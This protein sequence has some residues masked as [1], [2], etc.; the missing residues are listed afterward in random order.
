[1]KAFRCKR[2]RFLVLPV[3]CVFFADIADMGLAAGIELKLESPH[4]KIVVTLHDGDHLKY[5]ILF[6]GKLVVTDSTLGIIVDGR[7]LGE[8]V[9]FGAPET[10]TINEKYPVMGVH[11]TATNHCDFS[12]IPISSRNTKWQLAVRVFDDGVAYRYQ[13]PGTGARHIDGE[14]SEWNM[15]VGSRLFWQDAANTSYESK[16]QMLLIGQSSPGLEL[17]A[18]A[19]LQ[20][21]DNAG[22][23]TMTEANLINYS[24][25]SLR[26]DG[27]YVA[28]LVPVDK[29]SK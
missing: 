22:Y 11:N 7:D 29:V 28:W 8:D 21:P 6:Q 5:N 13:I 2:F 1:V 4:R 24:D 14:S 23:G 15:P 12:M 16:F 19:T 26:K 20:F 17:M 25:M 9:T 27:G 18:P 10:S 3:I